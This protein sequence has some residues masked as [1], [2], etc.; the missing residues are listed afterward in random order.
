MNS[1]LQSLEEFVVDIRQDIENN[2]SKPAFEAAF[3]RYLAILKPALDRYRHHLNN[4]GIDTQKLR[5]RFQFETAFL[6]TL[7][8]FLGEVLQNQTQIAIPCWPVYLSE[9]PFGWYEIP[10]GIRERISQLDASTLVLEQRLEHTLS[11]IITDI[12]SHAG[13]RYVG[14]YYTPL[15]LAKH[16]IDL[17]GL[18]PKQLLEGFSVLDPA[19]GGGIILTEVAYR[20]VE[21]TRTTNLDPQVALLSLTRHL[22]G[23]DIQPFAVVLTRTLL[24]YTCVPLFS[25]NLYI[26]FDNIFANIRLLDPLPK[27]KEYENKFHYIIANPPYLSTKREFLDFF[28]DYAQILHGHPNLFQLFLWWAVNAA[29]TDGTI[30]FLIPQS[31]L[32]GPYFKALRQELHLQTEIKRLTRMLDRTGIVE[33]ADQQMMA[34]CL[35]KTNGHSRHM[36]KIHIRVTRNGKD[37]YS[38]CSHE[39]SYSRV[40]QRIGGGVVWVVSDNILD[41]EIVERLE[42]IT[43]PL[44]DMPFLFRCGN[45]EFVWNEHKTLLRS[46]LDL[47]CVPLV[48]AVSIASYQFTFPHSGSHSSTQRQYSLVNRQVRSIL[49]SEPM[50]LIQRTTPRKVGRRLI[51][52]VLAN[53]FCEQYESYF[54]ENHV[55]YVKSTKNDLLYGLM[56]WLN[57]DLIN[58][59][60][61][62]RNG[63]AH[64]SVSELNGLPVNVDI[65]QK[66]SQIAE[67]ITNHSNPKDYTFINDLNRTIFDWLQLEP[68]HLQRMKE[69]LSRTEKIRT[70]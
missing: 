62:M 4:D 13:K 40:V 5:L 43:S 47:E 32:V 3:E 6:H 35:S 14:E 29:C 25:D 31:I 50:V 21:Y 34:L 48:S 33:N 24:V 8:V 51:S 28:R 46:E 2:S 54:L 1:L 38:D 26:P 10:Q 65:L 11:G 23:F 60:F 27:L 57:S 69:V 70:F 64:T 58:F 37:T 19:C 56:G 12:L 49:H 18:Q 63:T 45:G 9:Y 55:I 7:T 36:N 68:K 41:Y 52:C 66:I 22:H 39:I 17:S 15:P 30:S 61:Q 44:G 20:V 53:S 42:K 16:L 59:V 67:K